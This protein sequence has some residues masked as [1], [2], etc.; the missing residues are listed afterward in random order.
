MQ[1]SSHSSCSS[2]PYFH[3]LWFPQKARVSPGQP[4]RFCLCLCFQC[5]LEYL[6]LG[7]NRRVV[8]FVLHR[9]HHRA[10]TVQTCQR[11][12]SQLLLVTQG[13]RLAQIKYA[14]RTAHRASITTPGPWVTEEGNIISGPRGRVLHPL[15]PN[16]S[17]GLL[18]PPD[19]ANL[20]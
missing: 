2:C 1:W 12:S 8:V 17:T 11:T 20:I 6:M 3:C 19:T 14:E 13:Q 9:H 7:E 16:T 10:G 18:T 5:V 15:E 4:Q